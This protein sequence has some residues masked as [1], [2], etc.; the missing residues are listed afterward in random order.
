MQNVEFKS[1]LRDPPLARAAL[2]RLGA[3]L[4]ATLRQ[5]DTYYRVPDGRLKKRETEGEPAEYIFYHRAN[6]LRPKL[7]HF[8]IYTES[9][10]RK[11]FGL[12]PLPIWLTISKV[13]EVWMFKN[14]RVH[15][16]DVEHLGSYFE[17]EVLV[18]PD[19]HVGLC[20]MLASDIRQR[21]APMLGENI[22]VSYA[23][24]MALELETAEER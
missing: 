24:L 19:R 21:L 5:V 3:T 20:H 7:S 2:T 22:A 23:D 17:V 15:L 4:A 11:R 10:A 16:D 14:A 6:L 8:T 18:T 9:E 1:E 12:M 13:R